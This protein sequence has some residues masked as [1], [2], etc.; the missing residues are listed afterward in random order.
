MTTSAD[1]SARFLFAWQLAAGILLLLLPGALLGDWPWELTRGE[2]RGFIG[3]LI[4]LG[5]SALSHQVLRTQHG[6]K[7]WAAATTATIVVFAFLFLALLLLRSTASRMVLLGAFAIG[8]AVLPLPFVH[9]PLRIPGCIMLAL[10]IAAAGVIATKKHNPDRTVQMQRTQTLVGTNLYNLSVIAHT[11]RV[12]YPAVR[13]GGMARLGERVL[14]ASGDGALYTLR[15]EGRQLEVEPLSYRVP[16]N[17]TQ[18]AAAAGRE[19]REPRR[20]SEYGRGAP[21]GVQ[22]WRFRTGS[23]LLNERG[24]HLQLL[25]SHHYWKD[26]ERC[27]L[28]RISAIDI[29]HTGRPLSGAVG[30]W[31]TVFDTQPCLPL[32]GQDAKRGK[33]PFQ[34]EEMGGRM[35]LLDQRT[36]LLTTGDHSFSGLESWQ[37]FSQDPTASYG[38]VLQIDLETGAS[39]VFTS[40]HRN[41]QGL[42]RDTQGN[43]WLTEH[44]A[45][46]GDELNLLQPGENYGWP[47]VTY[48][49]DYNMLAWP[50]NSQQ[51]RHEGF[52][53]PTYAWVPS[54]GVTSLI[55]MQGERFAHWRGDLLAGSLATRSLYRIRLD[56]GHVMFVEPIPVAHRVRDLI[57]LTD[58]RIIVWTDEATVLEI[59]PAQ[60][61]DGEQLFASMCQSCHWLNDGRSHRAGPDLLGILGKDIASAEGFEFSPALRDVRGTWNTEQLQRYLADPQAFAP[62]TTMVFQGIEDAT[63]RELL[64]DYLRTAKP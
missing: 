45:K 25:A 13:G 61:T 17:G 19:Y 49:T 37:V 4:A 16:L 44:G 43:L 2:L 51:G 62:G 14:L 30:E 47:L 39:T 15:I 23:I 52:R 21:P 35:L 59:A 42:I 12:P 3:C 26:D 57:E 50:L 31:R 18:F 1:I 32:E 11:G 7:R 8:I 38:K 41:P 24:E 27:F 53:K 63:Q 54:L 64:I 9:R 55:Q 33:N 10:A 20:S 29:D 34:G 48:G 56:D 22:T 28:V 46:G 58:G 36:V 60:G 6:F 40:G 5:L